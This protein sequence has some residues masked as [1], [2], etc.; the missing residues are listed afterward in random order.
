MEDFAFFPV[1]GLDLD[2]G[3]DFWAAEL[4]LEMD[5]R[6]EMEGRKGRRREVEALDSVSVRIRRA[7]ENEDCGLSLSLRSRQHNGVTANA[8]ESGALYKLQEKT[9]NLALSM[10]REKV[11]ERASGVSD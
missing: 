6:A 2:L 9:T 7:L 1:E 8:N 4:G 3:L 11:V 5:T 10:L